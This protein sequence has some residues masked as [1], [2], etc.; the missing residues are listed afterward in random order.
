MSFIHYLFLGHF[1]REGERVC[2][3][4]NSSDST[5]RPVVRRPLETEAMEGVLREITG[6]ESRNLDF[7]DEWIIGAEDG[8]LICDKYTRNPEAIDFVTRLVERTDCDIYDVSAHTDIA[9]HDWL[10]VT[11]ASAKP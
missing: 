9:L 1:E 6:S 2:F 5:Y 11:H 3:A 8:Y 10:A 7:P 4:K